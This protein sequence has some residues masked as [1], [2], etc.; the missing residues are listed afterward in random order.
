KI[1]DE[2]N[3]VA[4]RFRRGSRMIRR[5]RAPVFPRDKRVGVC[6]EIM[7]QNVSDCVK[8]LRHLSRRLISVPD[9]AMMP[10]TSLQG[11]PGILIMTSKRPYRGVFPVAPTIFDDRGNLDLDGQ[12]R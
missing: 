3:R 2:L 9:Q 1:D 10:H 5:K 12:R 11:L 7:R 6:A 4:R 8:T